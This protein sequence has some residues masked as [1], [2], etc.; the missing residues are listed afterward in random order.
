MTLFRF[1]E[2]RKSFW[3]QVSKMQET[4]VQVCM[5]NYIH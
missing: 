4:N 2:K 5:Q 3:T 1:E